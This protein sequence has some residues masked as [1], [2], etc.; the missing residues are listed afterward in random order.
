VNGPL[1]EPFRVVYS[2][3]MRQQLHELA[4]SSRDRGDGLAFL[5][6]LK[7]FHR[8]LTVYPQFGEPLTDLIDEPEQSGSG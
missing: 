6:A 1:F 7:E 8:R 5:A 3:R 4:Q 2:E